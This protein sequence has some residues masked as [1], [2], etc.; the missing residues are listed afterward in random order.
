M[1]FSFISFSMLTMVPAWMPD[2]A[3]L[4][5]IGVLK[6]FV[7]SGVS[8]VAI[9][10]FTEEGQ[11]PAVS[12]AIGTYLNAGSPIYHLPAHSLPQ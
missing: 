5:A 8:A 2:P 9:A 7:I 4:I 6:G 10:Y 1:V 3:L 12:V 11:L